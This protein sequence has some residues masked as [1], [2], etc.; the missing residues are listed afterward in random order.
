M[1]YTFNLAN[2]NASGSCQWERSGPRHPLGGAPSERSESSVRSRTAAGRCCRPERQPKTLYEKTG[3]F[4]HIRP[5]MD[6]TNTYL[7][8]SKCFVVLCLFLFPEVVLLSFHASVF[9][10]PVCYL[11]YGF[12]RRTLY[13][14]LINCT[15]LSYRRSRVMC[16][17]LEPVPMLKSGDK[18]RA[19][20]SGSGVGTLIAVMQFIAFQSA[21]C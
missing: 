11:K 16:I 19:S 5:N 3:R 4:F 10:W 14:M 9:E 20:Q 15:C 8:L 1:S 7:H 13:D 17:D 6:N 18:D 2:C 12:F 21:S